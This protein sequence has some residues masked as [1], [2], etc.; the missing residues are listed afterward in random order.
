MIPLRDENPTSSR[1]VVTY[2]LVAICAAVFLYMLSLGSEARIERFVLTY[3]AIPAEIS[4]RA[5][6][7]AAAHYPTLVTS[8]FLHGGWAHL[9]GNMLYLWIFGD[10]VED[11]LGHVGYAIFYLIAGV[12]AV[13]AHIVTDAASQVPLIGASGAIA[14]VLGGYLVLHP[15]AR[16]L[17]L[18]PFGFYARV[19]AVPAFFFL[20][21]WFLMQFLYGLASLGA[22]A[23]GV[24]WWA[25]VGG[26]VAGVVLVPIFGRRRRS[27][28]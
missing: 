3:G 16:I 7:G 26:F 19:V 4:G 12:A 18:V 22:G 15:R 21:I 17:S 28:G 20:P 9:I 13:V 25:H 5:G 23:V 8:M 2:L 11:A 24:A 1:P 27:L 14:G 6:G 10:N